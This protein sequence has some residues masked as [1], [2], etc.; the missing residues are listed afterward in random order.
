ML[1]DKICTVIAAATSLR[2]VTVAWISTALALICALI[3]AVD[4][5]FGRRQHMAI[6]KVVWPVTAL[7]AGPLALGAYFAF[8]RRR[9]MKTPG[10]YSAEQMPMQHAKRPMWQAAAVGTTHCGAGCMLGDFIAESS[11]FLLGATLLFGSALLT[12]Y[13]IDFIAAYILGIVFQYFAVVLMRHL[14]FGKGIWAAIKAD[15]LSL[16]AFQVGMYAWMAIYQKCI[17]HP[18]LEANSPVYWFMMQIGMIAGFAT[19]Y[20]MNWFLIKTGIKEAM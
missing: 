3:V 18:S 15:S 5:V 16:I 9:K 13:I 17:F 20:P 2:L 19:S 1:G 14:S 12:S 4:V 7:Y 10:G 11:L 8:G 6:M